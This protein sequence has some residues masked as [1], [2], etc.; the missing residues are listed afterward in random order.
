MVITTPHHKNFLCYETFMN[1]SDFDW[2]FHTVLYGCKMWSLTAREKYRLRVFNNRVL[3]K[4]FGHKRN[5]VIRECRRLHN[6]EF[7]DLYSWPNITQVIKSRRMRWVGNP[8]GKRD[9]S[10][11]G[12]IILKWIF[13][14]QAG[15]WGAHGLD[16]SGWGR[17]R[18]QAVVNAAMN[19]QVP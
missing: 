4:I 5:E 10:V 1:T 3:R 8:E 6:K 14:M 16:W 12:R 18:W 13:K 19:P 7:Y 11:D 17:D 9:L 15:G 2:T